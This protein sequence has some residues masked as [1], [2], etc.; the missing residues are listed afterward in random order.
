MQGRFGQL[1]YCTEKR[2]QLVEE[3]AMLFTALEQ[4]SNSRH[5][6]V[7][8]WTR[9]LCSFR[10]WDKL[11]DFSQMLHWNFFNFSW[12]HKI[13][14]IRSLLQLN[15]FPHVS[16]LKSFILSWTDLMWNFRWWGKPKVFSQMSHWKFFNF[17]WTHLICISSSFE[18]LNNFSQPWHL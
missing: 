1:K 18:S 2:C 12:T 3:F 5:Y 17:S 9:L 13:C 14:V 11:K 7:R 8:L 6:E 15:D 16:H 4:M 10:V